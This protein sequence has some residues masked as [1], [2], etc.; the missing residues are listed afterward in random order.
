MSTRKGEFY[1]PEEFADAELLKQHILLT[2]IE[3]QVTATDEHCAL[4]VRSTM[5]DMNVFQKFLSENGGEREVWNT[6]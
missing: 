4:D 5:Y 6:L 3:S 2:L 1:Y